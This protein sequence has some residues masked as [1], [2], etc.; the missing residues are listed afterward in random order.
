MKMSYENQLTT[1]KNNNVIHICFVPQVNLS[2]D[3]INF[4]CKNNAHNAHQF[5]KVQAGLLHFKS[6]EVYLIF[7]SV[8]RYHL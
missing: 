8:F 3:L 7:A 6:T 1:C 5:S 2:R 4:K